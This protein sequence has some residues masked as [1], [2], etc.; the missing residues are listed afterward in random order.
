VEKIKSHV[1]VARARG[2]DCTLAYVIMSQCRCR[3]GLTAPDQHGRDDTPAAASGRDD[4]SI[5][6]EKS[7]SAISHDLTRA[8]PS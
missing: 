6:S 1:F 2:V 3:R 7:D 8:K 5:L 4:R